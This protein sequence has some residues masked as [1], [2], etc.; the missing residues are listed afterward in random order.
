M[1]LSGNRLGTN[2]FNAIKASAPSATAKVTDNDLE[3]MW[4]LI[5]NEIIDEFTANG[6]V[7]TTVST[8]VITPDTINGTGAGPGVGTI[9]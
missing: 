3:A 9:A 6:V 1:A 4:Q 2:I 7:N 8:V 5:G